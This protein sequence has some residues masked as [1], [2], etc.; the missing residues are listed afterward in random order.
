MGDVTIITKE[1]L[2]RILSQIAIN[3]IEQNEKKEKRGTS[4]KAPR[5]QNQRTEEFA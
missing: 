2:E 1:R 5:L 3:Q 4:N